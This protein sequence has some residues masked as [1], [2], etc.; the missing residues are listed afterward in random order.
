MSDLR[1]WGYILVI[2]TILFTN[3]T[4]YAQDGDKWNFS[5]TGFSRGSGF[6]IRPELYSGLFA[7]LGYQINPYVQLSG[8]LGF[9]LDQYGGM[10]TALG[11]RTYTSDANWAAMFD[12][13]IGLVSIQGLSLTRHTI[14]GGASYKDFDFGAG[15]MYITDGYDSGIGLSITLGYKIRCYKHR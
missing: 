5:G 15:L 3:K 9:G 10:I 1:R 12:Y 7:T 13:H 2:A 6:V 8:G 4:S 14:I 11:I